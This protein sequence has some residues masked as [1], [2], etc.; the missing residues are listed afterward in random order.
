MFNPMFRFFSLMACAALLIVCSSGARAAEADFDDLPL[1]PESFWNGPD[2]SGVDVPDPWGAPLPVR[3]GS[4]SSGGVT[5][6]NQ[7]NLNYG[8][9]S[10]FAY[11]N[12]SDTTTPGFGNQHSAI[13]GTGFGPGQDNYGVAFGYSDVL[14][15]NNI[16]ELQE[17]PHFQ[18]PAGATIEGAYF[19]N[20]TYS[21]LSMLDGDSFA[22]KFGGVLGNDA[23]W[24]KL[25]VY[26]A[27]GSNVPLGQV[28]E[29]YLADF[30]FSDN[31]L[32]YIVD[33]WTYVDLSPLAAAET[34]FFNLTSSDVGMFGMNTPGTFAI[35]NI[36]Y[37][38]VPEPST[39]VLAGLGAIVLGVAFK[40]RKSLC[41]VAV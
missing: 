27:D 14:D 19:T 8:S 34:L 15:S 26:G 28:V 40:R 29:F 24:F 30:R 23:D 22:K 33:A 25:S 9:W 10:G 41:K 7:H 39:F 35:D 1:A 18:L 17:L 11:S 3:V 38:P 31:N 6:V 13:T 12:T 5:F 37:T 2:P 4:F 20:T 21:Y 32:D 16:S 36:L